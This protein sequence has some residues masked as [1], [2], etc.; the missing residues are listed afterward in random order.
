MASAT[1]KTTDSPKTFHSSSGFELR[2]FYT[3]ADIP[4]S[5]R[6][7]A[8]GEPGLAPYHRGWHATGYRTKPWRIFQ[9]SGF[10]KP[11]DENARIKFLL[12][13][14]ETGFIMEHDRN[15]ADH[16]YDVDHPDV[17]ARRE[18]VGLTGAVMQSV[19]DVAICLDGLPVD[20][21]FG[22]AGGAVVQHAPFA[23]AGYWTVARKRG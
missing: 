22:H 3:A 12:K 7:R 6:E 4:S 20:T 10:G 21:S 18:D 13:N 5:H 8:Q 17:V 11:E 23:L 14:G 15:T 16:C 1:M 9:L 19:R 2:S